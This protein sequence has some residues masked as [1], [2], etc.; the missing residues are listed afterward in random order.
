MLGELVLAEAPDEDDPVVTLAEAKAQAR[1]EISDDN[2]YIEALVAAATRY[3]EKATRRQFVT[4]T[5]TMVLDCFH[6]CIT[7]PLAPVSAIDEI[8]YLDVDGDTQV[9]DSSVYRLEP[10]T[11]R[12][13]TAYGE[14][15]P[16][17]RSTTGAVQIDFVAG[18]G[19]A[20]DVPD[21]AKLAIKWLVAHWYESRTAADEVDLKPIPFGVEN[22]ITQLRWRL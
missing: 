3:V 18:Y 12:L 21:L 9:L 15:W 7:I 22:V 19:E 8:R 6:D 2:A 16:S 20:A 17:T 5:W 10:T 14:S 4:A 13:T 1:V 11:K